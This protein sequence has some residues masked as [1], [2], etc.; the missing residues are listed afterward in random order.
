MATGKSS[1][2]STR[3]RASVLLGVVLTG[4]STLS[5]AGSAG[6]RWQVAGGSVA[7]G[8][9]SIAQSGAAT[10]IQQ[11]SN[12]LVINWNS[13]NIGAGESVI[14]QQPSASAIALNRVTGAGTSQIDGAL[15][16]NGQVWVLNPN[17][18]LF[19]HSAQV[20]MGGLVAS[21]LRLSDSQFLAGNYQ[22]SAEDGQGVVRNQ[23]R[24]NGGYVA[25]LCS[26]VSNSGS[27]HTPGGHTALGAGDAITLNFDGQHLLRLRVNAGAYQALVDN[28]AVLSFRRASAAGHGA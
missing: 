19:G 16:A 21:T 6:G 3:L 13:F 11:T 18:V 2:A 10:T 26:Q 24:L 8:T 1:G 20:N 14:F 4:T 5:Q 12:K 23:G 17:G 7:T 27:I 25:L 15:N 22:F 28:P 9:G